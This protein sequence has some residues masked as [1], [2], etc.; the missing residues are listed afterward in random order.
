MTKITLSP[1]QV[2]SPVFILRREIGHKD[3]KILNVL[4]LT[5]HRSICT[6]SLDIL[7]ELK[8]SDL[9]SC[10]L[11]FVEAG[12]TKEALLSATRSFTGKPPSANITSPG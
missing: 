10:F 5:I 12:N 6:R 9:L 7:R 8:I 3:F 4:S 11:P 1:M 2:Y